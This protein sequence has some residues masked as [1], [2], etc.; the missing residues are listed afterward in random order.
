MPEW[1]QTPDIPHQRKKE[2][3]FQP[4]VGKDMFTL[5]GFL[6]TSPWTLSRMRCDVKSMLQ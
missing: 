4:T 2:F 1:K 5:L 3:T 6:R